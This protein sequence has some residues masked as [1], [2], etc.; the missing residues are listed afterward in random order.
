MAALDLIE[1][2]VILIQE[3]RSFD[4][5]LGYLSLPPYSRG[6]VEGLKTDPAWLE[7][8]ANLFAGRA[9][10]PFQMKDKRMSGDP[11]HD[12]DW[13]GLQI[14]SPNAAGE[15]PMRNFVA[16]YAH[17]PGVEIGDNP[18]VMGYFLPSEAP[19]TDFFA[20]SFA[21]CDHWFASLPAGTQPNRLMAMSG[22]TP[23]ENN[24]PVFLPEQPL[25]YD[26]LNDHHVRWRVYHEGVPFFALMQKWWPKIANPLDDNFR[27]LERL[28]VDVQKEDAAVAP[29][30]GVPSDDHPPTSITR[31]QEL[32]RKVY[33]AL[34]S[35]PAKWSKTMLVVTYDEHGGFFDH[36]SPLPIRTA[37]P[38]GANYH[39]FDSTGVRVPAMVVSPFVSPAR[40][41]K[42]PMD[43]TSILRLLGE[44]FG[45]GSY[46]DVVDRRQAGPVPLSSVADVLDLAAP[47]QDIPSPPL[48]VP[49]LPSFNENTAAFKRAME[50]MRRLH[51]D[52]AE[53]K[54][55]ELWLSEGT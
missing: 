4:H 3:N 5:M 26:W 37:P 14:G 25:V 16:G 39:P 38:T 2:I 54:F 21:I 19:L 43:H 44:K 6:D 51:P 8:Y 15:Y 36:V 28:P 49:F 55:P 1:T 29:H 18:E 40:V 7:R 45:G 34:T 12:R 41:F 13:I 35:N 48:A 24:A 33:R 47:R 42:H 31:G 11:P 10:K 30:V 9:Y 17:A 50:T 32:F 52:E 46:S 20:Q 23:I 53:D 22:F 27:V